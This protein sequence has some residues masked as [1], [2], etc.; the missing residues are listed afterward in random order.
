M[1]LIGDWWKERN[2]S[3]NNGEN[4]FKAERYDQ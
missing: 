1:P 4:R 2:G 3:I